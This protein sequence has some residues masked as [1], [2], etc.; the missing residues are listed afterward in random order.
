[1]EKEIVVVTG[2]TASGKSAA[3]DI[4]ADDLNC[5]VI[6]CDSKQ[7]YHGVPILTDQP[8]SV[9]DIHKLYG[10][11]AP[12]QNYSAGL[13]LQDVKREVQQ[14][15]DDNV[16]P[17]ITGGSGMYINSLVNGI[18][19]IPAIDPEVR[20]TARNLLESLGN[21]AF[22]EALVARDSNAARLHHNNTHQILRAFEV[23]EQTGTSIF[24]WWERSPRIK[25]FENC[26][27]LVL[28]PPRNKLYD[29]INRRFLTMMQTDAISEV[30]YLMSL[31]LPMHAPVMKAHGAPEIVQYLQGK[32]EFMEAV[33]I[34]QKNTRHY[35]KRQCTWFRTQL[36]CDTRFFSSQ[37]EIIDHVL[38]QYA[39]KYP[40][41][42]TQPHN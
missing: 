15:W 36:P 34:A 38:A 7:I 2:P 9:R 5:R 17:V 21:A 30:K 28:L 25:P 31:N 23:L 16:L 27:V 29:K 35:A 39:S 37:N 10:Y 14:A 8:V 22:Y 42:H 41:T 11:V 18:S 20:K 33:E 6:N 32:I 1:M 24:T 13:W 19:D 26:E 12:T 3:C 40:R 4:I